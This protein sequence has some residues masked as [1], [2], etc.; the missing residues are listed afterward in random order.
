MDWTPEERQKAMAYHRIMTDSNDAYP[1]TV[2]PLS[3]SGVRSW[4]IRVGILKTGK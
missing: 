4:L 2:A 1:F 3:W